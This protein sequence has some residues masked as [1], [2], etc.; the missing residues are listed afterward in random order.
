MT[1]LEYRPLPLTKADK[2]AGRAERR[3]KYPGE[4]L[5]R[6]RAKHRRGD[7]KTHQV[8]AWIPTGRKGSVP[9]ELKQWIRDQET[10]FRENTL[11]VSSPRSE[12]TIAELLDEFEEQGGMDRYRGIS[13][14]KHAYYFDWWRREFGKVQPSQLRRDKVTE[15]LK[16]TGKPTAATRNRYRTAM[17]AVFKDAVRE[18]RIDVNP[19]AGSR[20][21]EKPKIGD[22]LTDKQRVALL[23]AVKAEAEQGREERFY[24]AVALAL[25]TGMRLGEVWNLTAGDIDFERQWISITEAKTKAGERI[26]P[27]RTSVA[28]L[29]RALIPEGAEPSR[30]VFQRENGRVWPRG[31]WKRIVEAAGLEDVGKPFHALRHDFASRCID[32]GILA[33]HLAQLLGHSETYVTGR[34]TH[35]SQEAVA[36]LFGKEPE[37]EKPKSYR[38]RLPDLPAH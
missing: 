24:P 9:E 33:Q 20:E 12:P 32:N 18:H 17:S 34:Y 3:P 38:D 14:D 23:K 10:A 28:P 16:D 8:S 6:V 27:L 1:T 7:A 5:W 35:S 22:R 2:E 19:L 31:P 11:G 13:R 37:E 21:I 30:S 36:M 26:V 29:L 4:P 15:R 25:T